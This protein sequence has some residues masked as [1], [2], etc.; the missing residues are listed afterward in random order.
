MYSYVYDFINNYY[1]TCRTTGVEISSPRG[2][3][4]LLNTD[5]FTALKLYFNE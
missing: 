3:K 1:F 5:W 2:S 4:E